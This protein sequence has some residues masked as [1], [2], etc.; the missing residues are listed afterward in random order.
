MNSIHMT[1][2]LQTNNC[3][4][5]IKTTMTMGCCICLVMQSDWSGLKFYTEHIT[6]TIYNG[7]AYLS[8]VL[9]TEYADIILT[10]MM[11]SN[12]DS[13]GGLCILFAVA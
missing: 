13:V 9:A 4:E 7:L 8:N 6:G 2:V 3:R 10:C 11:Q 12:I 1:S 5:I